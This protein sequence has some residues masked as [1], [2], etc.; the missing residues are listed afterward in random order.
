MIDLHCHILP[1]VD[2]G[3]KDLSD[4]ILMAQKA[5]EQGIQT[6]VATPHHLNN[7]YENP[8]Q[9]IL[10]KVEE[11]NQLL[12][13][14]KIDLRILPGQETRIYGEMADDYGRGDIQPVNDSPYVL[15]EFSSSHVPRYTEKLFYDLQVKGLVPIIVHPERNQEIIEQPDLLYKL[16]Q[17][18]ALTQVTASSICGDF[19]KKI[20]NF[21][22]QLI[23]ANLTH[24]IASDAHNIHNRTFKLREAFDLI[25]EKYGNEMVYMFDDNAALVL[26]GSNVYKEV[27]EKI[28]KR[29]FFKIF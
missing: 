12:R 23:D 16:V 13:D 29:K 10:Q 3:A 8:K 25:D 17:N 11:L 15:V 22:M 20:K 5:V 2:D 4:S 9:R 27:P 18:G 19:G 14:E 26:D 28:K 21:S 24:F 1:G 7:H 6:I